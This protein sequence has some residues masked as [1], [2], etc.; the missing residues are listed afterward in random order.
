MLGQ[1]GVLLILPQLEKHGHNPWYFR[2][3]N[4]PSIHIPV[5]PLCTYNRKVGPVMICSTWSREDGCMWWCP[6][7]TKKHQVLW[8]TLHTHQNWVPPFHPIPK[9]GMHWKT[10]S[11]A[12]DWFQIVKWHPLFALQQQLHQH[13]C[14]AGYKCAQILINGQKFWLS[15]NFWMYEPPLDIPQIHLT[16]HPQQQWQ[17]MQTKP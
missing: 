5:V 7:A 9:A 11:S 17:M 15:L 12:Y 16:H 14:E 6:A 2:F 10:F 3:P 4:I 1:I 8:F 13:T